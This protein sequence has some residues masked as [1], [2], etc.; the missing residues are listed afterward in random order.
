MPRLA[1]LFTALPFLISPAFA[2]DA[3][4]GWAMLPALQDLDT[5]G[6]ALL[7]PEEIGGTQVPEAFD[8]DGDGLFSVVELS[9]G[10]FALSD[11]DDS[12]LLENDELQAMTGLAGA[13]V[14][15]YDM[16]AG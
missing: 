14:F 5:D 8:L 9:Q 10:Y 6:D 3:K 16:G 13:G 4:L 2:Q 7:S 12:G 15:E 11:V 1:L